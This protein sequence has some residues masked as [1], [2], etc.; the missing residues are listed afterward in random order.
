MVYLKDTEPWD[1]PD[2]YYMTLCQNCHK[3]EGAKSQSA[4]E[5]LIYSARVRFLSDQIS[6]LSLAINGIPRFGI[7][8][9]EMSVISWALTNK[10]ILKKLKDEYFEYIRNTKTEE[11]L[12]D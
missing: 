7:L 4:I 8:D 5:S 6:D 3:S 11:I 12:G 9:V 2:D 10:D 1:Y